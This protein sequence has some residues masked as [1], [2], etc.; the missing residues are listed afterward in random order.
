LKKSCDGVFVLE[1][2]RR[3][4]SDVRC[5]LSGRLGPAEEVGIADN[6]LV[7]RLETLCELGAWRE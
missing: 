7:L 5:G 1:S 3:F 4:T 6:G 2:S